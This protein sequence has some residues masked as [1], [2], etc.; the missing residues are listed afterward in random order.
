MRP[1]LGA[2]EVGQ[3]PPMLLVHG[4]AASADGWAPQL[5]GLQDRFQLFAVD[6]RGTGRSP[7]EPGVDAYSVAEHAE[8]LAEFIQ[9]RGLPPPVL[10]GSSFG[11]VVALHLARTRPELVR[12][13]VLAEPPLSPQAT[14]PKQMVE[15]LAE[16]RRTLAEEG[17]PAGVRLFLRTVVGEADFEAMPAAW[18][19]RAEG[20]WEAVRRDVEALAGYDPALSGLRGLRV[21]AL[22]LGGGRSQGYYVFTLERLRMLL[23]V[24]ARLTLDGAGH[25]MHLDQ[26]E[27]FNRAVTAFAE[28]FIGPGG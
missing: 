23:P 21:P 11:A 6:R 3:G 4:S 13:M 5:R 20:L 1:P 10:C 19:S 16:F 28:R 7:L 12:G 15:F 26:P 9:A 27:A 24:S 18:R 25:M 14:L 8:D 17:G 2:R 22:M